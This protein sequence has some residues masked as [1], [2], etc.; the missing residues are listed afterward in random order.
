MV[1]LFW[2][3][4]PATHLTVSAGCTLRSRSSQPVV[5]SLSSKSIC[6]RYICGIMGC[7]HHVRHT[8]YGPYVTRHS[9]M[10]KGSS[11]FWT[12]RPSYSND[13]M[14]RTRSHYLVTTRTND[15][16]RGYRFF[17]SSHRVAFCS[18]L[19]SNRIV[20]TFQ[21]LTHDINVT[22]YINTPCPQK[23]SQMSFCHN[24]KTFSQISTKF[25]M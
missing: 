3:R 11:E 16:T 10:S 1:A 7:P 8:E 18:E 21:S 23:V 4:N 2:L 12:Q 20:S 19:T 5:H 9:V 25:S 13:C 17:C 24:F 14:G 22:K 6:L 15:F